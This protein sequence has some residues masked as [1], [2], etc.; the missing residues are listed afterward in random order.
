MLV[1]IDATAGDKYSG[2]IHGGWRL[3]T[4]DGAS[5]PATSIVDAEMAAA[6]FSPFEELSSGESGTGWVAFQV[7]KKADSYTLE[8]KR[9]AANVIG[10][11]ETIPAKIWSFPL[12]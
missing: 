6:G 3:K 12:T 2:G 7:N 11:E 1:Q 8:Y 9:L 4:P 10:S 5:G